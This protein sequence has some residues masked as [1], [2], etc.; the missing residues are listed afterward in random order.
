VIRMYRGIG[1][2]ETANKRAREVE[3]GGKPVGTER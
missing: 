1:R 3:A 2:K